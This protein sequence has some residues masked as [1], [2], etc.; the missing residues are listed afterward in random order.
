MTQQPEHTD[1]IASAGQIDDPDQ[2]TTVE[3]QDDSRAGRDTQPDEGATDGD[4][5]QPGATGRSASRQGTADHGA[6]AHTAGPGSS[7]E[8]HG[9]RNGLPPKAVQETGFPVVGEDTVD[10]QGARD[11]DSEALAGTRKFQPLPGEN[12]PNI[13]DN[14]LD[15]PDYNPGTDQARAAANRTSD[16]G[17]AADSTVQYEDPE[18]MPRVEPVRHSSMVEERVQQQERDYDL[19]TT[20]DGERYLTPKDLPG[21]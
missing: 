5:D 6:T 8:E 9:T 15:S 16:S 1:P 11:L 20:E 4:P 18:N 19:G 14:P 12:N 13:S 3:G 17:A 2:P 7:H 10:A 21:S